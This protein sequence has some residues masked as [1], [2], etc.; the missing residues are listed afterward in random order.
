MAHAAEVS[1]NARF[2]STEISRS[3]NLDSNVSKSFHRNLKPPVIRFALRR[4]SL[5]KDE[6]DG[7]GG[8]QIESIYAVKIGSNKRGFPNV[9]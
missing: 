1:R 3:M 8:Y 9:K 6:V 2:F 5:F 4:C 7:K